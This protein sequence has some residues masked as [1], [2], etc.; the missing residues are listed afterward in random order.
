M[1][2]PLE[3]TLFSIA[4]HLTSRKHNLSTKFG[5]FS[6]YRGSKKAGVYAKLEHRISNNDYDKAGLYVFGHQLDD[7]PAWKKT[8]KNCKVTDLCAVIDGY[9]IFGKDFT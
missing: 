8:L 1:G 4:T 9:R 6:R 2:Y 3:A 5:Y 7:G